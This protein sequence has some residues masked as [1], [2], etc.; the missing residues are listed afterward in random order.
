MIRAPWPST[1]GQ[2]RAVRP[3]AGRPARRAIS[4]SPAVEGLEY[5]VG[6]V[7]GERQSEIVLFPGPVLFMDLSWAALPRL[8]RS[9]AA[10]ETAK[11]PK[12]PSRFQ[13][14][15]WKLRGI[16]DF[17]GR[18]R[19]GPC[20]DGWRACAS[21]EI[22]AGDMKPPP[23]RG[24]LNAPLSPLGRAPSAF[25]SSLFRG[26]YQ[27]VER[28]AKSAAGSIG[29]PGISSTAARGPVRRRRQP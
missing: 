5:L 22:G 12:C 24:R 26:L 21:L 11:T 2:M 28:R 19:G 13:A 6:F 25:L 7:A 9:W 4:M 1:L 27:G 29:V 20:G 18:A 15:A 14:S 8:G 23:S 3:R 17:A 10:T 16:N